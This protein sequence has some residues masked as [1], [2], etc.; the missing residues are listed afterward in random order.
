MPR[1]PVA[2]YWQVH[3][4]EYP[5]QRLGL[6]SVEDGNEQGEQCHCRCCN[7]KQLAQQHCIGSK[8]QNISSLDAVSPCNTAARSSGLPVGLTWPAFLLAMADLPSVTPV[9]K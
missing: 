8:K 6:A 7:P 5:Q 4:A 9:N 3:S 2:L 1:L